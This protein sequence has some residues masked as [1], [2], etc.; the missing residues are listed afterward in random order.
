[1]K[2]STPLWIPSPAR[3]ARAGITRYL[4]WLE[5]ERRLTFADY[6]SLWRWSVTEIEDFWSTIWDFC[7][8]IAHQ[9]HRR[10]LDRRTMPGAQWFEG[11]TL[12]YAEHS[13]VHA[14]RPEFARKPAIIAQSE[15]RPRLEVSWSALAEQTGALGATLKRL[16][17]RTGDRVVSY[18]PNIPETITALLATASN[19]AIW[20]SASPDM[21]AVSV[22]DRFRQ[23]EPKILFAV[24]GYRYGG[25]DLDRRDVVRELVRQLPTLEAVILVP[26]LNSGAS[27]DAID[28]GARRV[29]V[30]SLAEATTRAAP[31]H[32]I[33]VPFGHPL[34]IVYSSGTTGMPKPIVH[35]HGGTT[36]ENLKSSALHL[37]IG[38]DDRF[39]WFTSTSWIMWNVVVNALQSGCTIMQFDGNPGYPDINTLWRFGE[40]EHATLFGIS[41]AFI[42]MCMKAGL[43]P[44]DTFDLSRLRTI[45]CT[46][47]PLT[48][49]G[50]RWIYQHVHSDVMLASISGGTDPGTAF[51]SA[52]PTLPIYAGEMQCR[53][54]GVATDAFDDAGK[55]VMDHVGELVM[56]API[57]SMPLYFWGDKDGKR[58]FESYFETY[59]GVWR[60]GDWLQLVP[61]PESVTGIIYGR[62]DSTI[63]RYGIRMGTSELYRVVE[64]FPEVADS[65]VVDLEYLGRESFLALFVVLREPGTGI[66]GIGSKGLALDGELAGRASISASGAADTGV[67]AT[68]RKQLLDAIRT[69]LSARHVPNEAFAIPEVP[70][71]LSG[72][73]MEVPV[74]KILLGHPVEK[75]VNRDSMANPGSIDWF[76]AFARGRGITSVQTNSP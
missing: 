4:A 6:D 74:K 38:S 46:G 29:P 33:A 47:S 34:W 68:L 72:K 18:L 54:L 9:R 32:F 56:T 59:P 57:P 13:L 50:Y 8:V 44:R 21:G 30:M 39:F 61:R 26:Y 41:P 27:L 62:S 63:N 49:D 66:A 35:G 64:E 70:R 3:I 10:V 1:M 73:K 20:S 75:S 11:A 28:V 52:C 60:H 5:R 19:G 24:D 76:V 42:A 14:R 16:G 65:L 36:I 55:P 37:D 2:T 69:K 7:G 25:K 22:L 58:Y 43:E 51:L 53:G 23:I 17:V 31:C 71:T 12:N 67:P 48:E 15:I 45:G 40:R